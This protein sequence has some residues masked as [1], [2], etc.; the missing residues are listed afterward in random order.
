MDLGVLLS[1]TAL[2]CCIIY[3]EKRTTDLEKNILNLKN[4]LAETEEWNKKTATLTGAVAML[5]LNVNVIAA[6]Q[7]AIV[8]SNQTRLPP[9]LSP[10]LGLPALGAQQ[11]SF[12]SERHLPNEDS[13]STEDTESSY[14]SST[15]T[16]G[17][18]ILQSDSNSEF[19]REILEG[20][21]QRD[22]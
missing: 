16:A 22:E 14:S 11:D 6:N 5:T 21:S 13:I 12:S 20:L 17:C 3:Q 18:R 19:T 2:G 10:L 7:N 1:G 8:Q 15:S 9:Q 4:R